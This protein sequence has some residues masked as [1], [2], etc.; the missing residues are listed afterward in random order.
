[1]MAI[2]RTSDGIELRRPDAL[3]LPRSPIAM[4]PALQAPAQIADV[5]QHDRAAVGRFE[6]AA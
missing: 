5:L 6:T 2:N 1:M 4:Q 3:H